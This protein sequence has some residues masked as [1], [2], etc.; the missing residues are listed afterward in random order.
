MTLTV[1]SVQSVGFGVLIEQILCGPNFMLI[2]PQENVSLKSMILRKLAVRTKV[3]P[4][5]FT[6]KCFLILYVL[7]TI[8]TLIFSLFKTHSLVG[9]VSCHGRVHC[10][11]SS[12]LIRIRIWV[13]LT[14]K[15]IPKVYLTVQRFKNGQ[16][17]KYEVLGRVV[18]IDVLRQTHPSQM[19]KA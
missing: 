13:D 15:N 4:R 10:W 19:A 6:K 18:H 9:G 5:E 11:Y 14:W 8:I 1:Q 7:C 16:L 17:E 3:S 2:G 12:Y